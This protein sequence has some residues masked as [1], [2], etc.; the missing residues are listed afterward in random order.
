MN[1]WIFSLFTFSSLF[2]RSNRLF[3]IL[4]AAE[5]RVKSVMGVGE[6]RTQQRIVAE[7]R[8]AR[9]RWDPATTHL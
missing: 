6:G 4:A 5:A 8:T 7:L 9:T 3:F 1:L 2:T